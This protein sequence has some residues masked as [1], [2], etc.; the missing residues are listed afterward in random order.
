MISDLWVFEERQ[1]SLVEHASWS[2]VFLS[3]WKAEQSGNADFCVLAHKQ[4]WKGPTDF[5]VEY[6]KAAEAAD[7][8]YLNKKYR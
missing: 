6:L 8:L 1:K 5:Q 3:S 2:T 4:Q 7:I